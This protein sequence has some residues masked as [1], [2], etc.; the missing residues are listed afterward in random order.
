M[1][2]DRDIHKSELANSIITQLHQYKETADKDID[3]LY[4]NIIKKIRNEYNQ[5][6][7]KINED[8]NNAEISLTTD[9]IGKESD[10]ISTAVIQPK[11]DLSKYRFLCG[12][13]L[14]TIAFRISKVSFT[15][16]RT[17]G[18]VKLLM[19]TFGKLENDV[20]AEEDRKQ[21]REEF[22]NISTTCNYAPAMSLY[23]CCAL[24]GI[25][26]DCNL[27]DYT[28]WIEKALSLN[29]PLAIIL[30][31]IDYYAG[32]NGVN[33]NIDKAGGLLKNIPN[34][35]DSDY[36]ELRYD[37]IGKF[38]YCLYTQNTTYNG[39]Y[40][41]SLDKSR[42]DAFSDLISLA[43]ETKDPIIYNILGSQRG[44]RCYILKAAE[45][46]FI[47][48]KYKICENKKFLLD[49]I[50]KKYHIACHN[51]ASDIIYKKDSKSAYLE[52][53]LFRA[54]D[55]LMICVRQGYTES[56]DLMSHFYMY[57]KGNFTKKLCWLRA[58]R[59]I[60]I[61]DDTYERALHF[62]IDDIYDC[63]KKKC[64]PIKYDDDDE[65]ARVIDDYIDAIYK[66][67]ISKEIQNN[68]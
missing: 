31:G 22:L 64:L 9:I 50:S 8:F 38:Y 43:E 30:R 65:K 5:L 28:I 52:S 63:L 35:S 68:L 34:M 15:S 23:A 13:N 60:D 25:G 67:I 59:D 17:R 6:K 47:H 32:Y 40:N 27:R 54:Y 48:A 12:E 57:F 46:G 11:Y 4:E 24:Y 21:A 56:F 33:K 10:N 49:A 37:L 14:P 20:K 42:C 18:T 53:K 62:D 51:F 39:R 26:G 55:L 7:L 2:A 1:Q 41:D 61:S 58:I 44:E 29:D 36:Y 3:L 66:D 45:Q 19:S 16:I